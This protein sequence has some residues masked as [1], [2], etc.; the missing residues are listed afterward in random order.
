MSEVT[1]SMEATSGVAAAYADRQRRSAPN[2]WWG[3]ALLI[4][5]EATLF[6]CL[7]ATYF[8]LAFQNGQWP[9]PGVPDP[10]VAL[11]LVL[12]AVLVA[13][14]LPISRAVRSARLANVTRVRMWLLLALLMQGAYFAVQMHEYLS[15]LDKI[16][17]SASSYGSIYF[18]MLGTHH[19]HVAVGLLLDLW[20]LGKLLGGLTNYRL[21]ALRVIAIYWYFV[22][23]AGVCVVLT[24]IYPSL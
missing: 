9:P 19:A 12:T 13:S 23:V 10:K 24:Q 20:L 6:G 1:R 8:Y 21:V 15:D 11:P 14:T 7:I 2:G 16:S 18:T 3:M 4:A 22:S 5:T 17:A